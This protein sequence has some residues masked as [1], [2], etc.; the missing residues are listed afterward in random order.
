MEVKVLY[1][2]NNILN[3]ITTRKQFLKTFIKEGGFDTFLD[4]E[5]KKIQCKKV[6]I[7]GNNSY[8]S[9]TDLHMILKSRYPL[10]TLK[11]TVNLLKSIIKEDQNIGM[12]WCTQINKCVMKYIKNSSKEYITSYSRKN[13]YTEKGE[14]GYSLQD[15]ENM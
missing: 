5:C 11:G 1:L 15:F 13:Y 14:D 8:R 2:K 3:N 4:K 12:V 7:G 9:V 10:T 6:S